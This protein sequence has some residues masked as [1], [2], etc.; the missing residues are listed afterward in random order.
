MRRRRAL[1]VLAGVGAAL[2]IVGGVL[3]WL[4][5]TRSGLEFAWHRV[6]GRLPGQ[7]RV[8]SLEGRLFGPLVANG[9]V[10]DTDTLHIEI[11]RA[12]LD[13]HPLG[14]LGRSFDVDRLALQGVAVTRRSAGSTA[15]APQSPPFTL[16][17]QLSLPVAV[18]IGQVLVENANYYSSPDAAPV[19]F[20][21][22]S[23]GVRLD[24]DQWLLHDIELRA[25]LATA[26]GRIDLEPRRPYAA[27]AELDW[28][29]HPADYPAASGKT[30]VSGD[31]ERL[32]LR[33]TVQPPYTLDAQL[34][35]T[36]P[37]DAAKLDGRLQTTLDPKAL[38]LDLPVRTIEVSAQVGGSLDS[39]AVDG[40]AKLNS[41][42]LANAELDLHATYADNT[43]HV[44]AL[45]LRQPKGNT[46]I[47]LAGSVALA[48]A[49]HVELGGDWQH[50][51]W[52][53][54]GEPVVASPSG[55]LQLSGTP[56]MLKA[57]LSA[58]VAGG[59]KVQGT[60]RR[61]GG[62]LDADLGWT[63]IA[64]PASS[65]EARSSKGRLSVAGTLDAYKLDLK[66]DLSM[67]GKTGH[68]EASGTGDLKGLM[69]DTIDAQVLGGSLSGKASAQWSPAVAGSA[70]LTASMLDPGL[71]SKRWA[72][73]IG[74]SVDASG[75]LEGQG[76]A[77]DIKALK[78]DGRLR[79][80][81]VN[82]DAEGRY[83]AGAL[84]LARL[85]LKSGATE[86]H[87]Q[88]QL[89]EHADLTFR[90]ASPDLGDVWPSF[91]GSLTAHGRVEGPR[92]KPRI[93]LDANGSGIEV[94]DAHVG[95]LALNADVDASGREPSS[96]ELTVADAML[97]GTEV[98]RLHAMGSGDAA[99]HELSL[100]ADTDLG[101]A[102]LAL[103]GTVEHPWEPDFA[104]D[105]DVGEA[106]VAYPAL[107]P[108]SL[109]KEAKG[110]LSSNAV[111]LERSCWASGKAELCLDATGGP[112]GTQANLALT[113]LPFAYFVPLLPE[114]IAVDGEISA[115]AEA[116]L[117]PEQPPA[118][119]IKLSSTPGRIRAPSTAADGTTAG[120]GPAGG[121]NA[122]GTQAA[123]SANG[124]AT[125]TAPVPTL[126]FGAAS[127]HIV[128]NAERTTIDVAWP[129]EQQGKIDLHAIVNRAPGR[130]VAE[131]AVTG[132]ADA[133]VNDLTFLADVIDQVDN[134]G[135]RLTGQLALSGT[136]GS[137]KLAGRV[138]LDDAHADLV[139][140][141]VA[142]K[143]LN[144]ALN[145]DGSGDVTVQASAESGGGTMTG[146]GNLRL[147]G[148]N[149]VGH[150]ELSGKSFEI[151]DTSDAQ[152]FV[153]PQLAIDADTERL[154]L[155]GT[156]VVPKAKFTP[157]EVPQ[158]AVSV[159]PDQVIVGEDQQNAPPGLTRPLYAKVKLQLGDDVTF[160]GLG[161][162]GTL[163]GGLQIVEAPKQP[164]TGSG[165]LSIQK[166]TYEAYGQKLDIRRGRLLFA[167]GPIT[168]P[169]VDV[170]AVRQATPE[171]LVGAR[172][173][174][175][176]AQPQL[177]LFSEP[178]LPKQEQLS[179]LIL[180]RSLDKASTSETS[181]LSNAAIALG[182][183]G[184]NFV[185][186][187]LNKSLG[188]QE[189]GIE[190]EPGAASK[191]A[192]FVIGKYLSPSLYVSYGFGLFQPVNTLK[193]R[194]T[195]SSHWRLQTES[196]S[197]GKGGDLLYHI[198]R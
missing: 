186:Q 102:K 114:P 69:L 50:L 83:A 128:S 117:A 11:R 181:A 7:V 61:E 62:R 65:P 157:R 40:R 25:P 111:T 110:R 17:V 95:T 183:K 72:G 94:P 4:A 125:A 58:Q 162:T 139:A 32:V 161:L 196:S 45:Q 133:E 163:T 2:V 164:T 106:T 92:E 193:L 70:Q 100:A 144:L 66:T 170:E 5:E 129:F 18:D 101:T 143:H 33:Q 16:P 64:W 134:T 121:Q 194:Y 166:G 145:G 9:L 176:L 97:S 81:A 43:V 127:G 54:T 104:W 75:S 126:D 63:D 29:L 123:A 14:L 42:E 52:P 165:E 35:V 99:Q 136:L 82:V 138:A 192:A 189:F 76:L 12:E 6:A 131:S 57:D 46:A 135:G 67:S 73:R 1:Q 22:A 154:N 178:T 34:V 175:T 155:T 48:P 173:Q 153:S 122:A 8:A 151:Y 152:V 113:G 23:L 36:Q 150:L 21:R 15:S 108:W 107:A 148:S 195:I 115:M 19:A 31:L 24:A 89:A 187:K 77:V 98:T 109:Q 38:G 30:T 60:V 188:F 159:S 191:T 84:N 168:R 137:P 90:L 51:T 182:L 20:E 28:T 167:G 141:G 74:G 149:P 37:L 158:G 86:L 116:R 124:T 68:I 142:V 87:A 49:T 147:A 184:G 132:N 44:G 41:E 174:G 39:I 119:D 190:T 171:I 103:T 79:N 172:V 179:Y 53:L 180:G 27:N 88:G 10:L 91:A 55:K 96:L 130:P 146:T 105:F 93:E 112:Q 85:E 71:V 169:G 80:R 185:S 160:D 78:L 140:P 3:A 177:S 120:G 59:G 56:D 26:S 118:I 156:V 198:E 13:W 47:D 197:V